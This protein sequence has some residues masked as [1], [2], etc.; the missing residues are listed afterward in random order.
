[1]DLE[2][3]L[4]FAGCVEVH[5]ENVPQLQ[6]VQAHHAVTC[7]QPARCAGEPSHTDSTRI[8]AMTGPRLSASCLQGMPGPGTGRVKKME[9]ATGFEPAT[10]SLGS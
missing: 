6:A 10:L 4:A 9:R 2:I 7:A 8:S 3:D 1:M 5:V